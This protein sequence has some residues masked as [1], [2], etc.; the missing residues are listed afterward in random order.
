MTAILPGAAL[1]SVL[2]T[3]GPARGVIYDFL[4]VTITS[5]NTATFTSQNGNG[6]ILASTAVNNPTN[7]L[8]PNNS[9]ANSQFT[10]LFLPS[11]VVQGW[12][13]RYEN[14]SFYTNTFVLTNYLLTTNT[15]FGVWNMTEESNTY[16]FK[17]YDINNALI[18]PPFTWNLFGYD[19]NVYPP[20][21]NIGWVHLVLNP[22]TGIISTNIFKP[23][24]TDSDGAFWNNIPTN[25]AK[26]VI[27]GALPP[28]GR[29]GV[30][31]YF[32]EP[33]PP[34]TIVCPPDVIVTICGQGTNVFYPM[35]TFIGDCASNIT[36]FYDPTNGA[37]FPLGTNTVHCNTVGLP[38]NSSCS[39]NVI[40]RNS[41]TNPPTITCPGDTNVF[42]CG[43]S[44]IVYYTVTA[45]D[46]SGTVVATN[47]TPPSGSSFPLGTNVVLC[48]AID[49][50]GNA[51]TCQFHVIVKT[52]PPWGV[53]CPSESTTL[54]VT[55]C[56]PLMPSVTNLVTVTN[57]CPIPGGLTFTQSPPV[58]ATLS[59]GQNNCSVT[60]CDTNGT[61][62]S[63]F[64]SVTAYL[65]AN[66]CQM[67]N[68]LVLYSGATNGTLLPGGAQDPQFTTAAP[69]FTTPHPYVPNPIHSLWLTNGPNSKWIGPVPGF[70]I[71]PVG[72]FA[73]TNRFFLCSTNQ[74]GI[75]GQ[76]TLDDGGAIWLNG[77]ATGVFIN[78]PAPNTSWHPVSIT[79]GFVPGWN[80]LVFYV[81][82]VISSVTGLR[83]ELIG[84]NC[85][86]ANCVSIN[87]PT[88]I[89][90]STCYGSAQV[91]YPTP[92]AMSACGYITS[93]VCAP[94]S[95]SYFPVGTSVVQCTAIDS[96]GNAATCSFTVTVTQV[97]Q[98]ACD[99][100][101]SINLAE[102]MITI[103]WPLDVPGAQ[104]LAADS[105][106][107]PVQW[108]PVP[109]PPQT[110]D[111][112]TFV[113]LPLL[114]SMQFF[115]LQ[116][117]PGP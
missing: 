26:I 82:N 80:N 93:V 100:N 51:S 23:S 42:T 56:P 12:L 87:C 88:N 4:P 2:L 103:R 64:F 116:Q 106:A 96:Q 8:S 76:W 92:A 48:M 72:V 74:A 113:T 85:C 32:A 43:T 22:A 97:I 5:T 70:T 114:N 54:S 13:T 101:V 18:S 19:D 79:S 46:D 68:F 108:Y 78:T 53:V 55:G 6:Y 21:V 50:C 40:V 45:T 15:I 75:G 20:D 7:A 95:G 98:T 77:T 63:C 86:V 9:V 38:T 49:P 73:Y 69:Q 41:D 90:Q 112:S 109:M 59:I 66:C 105:L 29:D 107:P 30:V 34:C 83:T 102:G 99:L 44:A 110:D 3:A 57:V 27:Q 36:V 17:A 62:Y 52:Y 11:G 89:S 35:P 1:A 104:L 67:Q 47:C 24:G 10:N 61:C 58:G 31:F 94:P 84:T 91:T 117:S 37:Y 111:T 71:S 33:K 25:T 65:S 28:A 14:N 39:F 115:I 81:T 16:A 60:V